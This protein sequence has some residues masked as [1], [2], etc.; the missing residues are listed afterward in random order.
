MFMRMHT[1]RHLF[2]ILTEQTK[3]QAI[4]WTR[5]TCFAHIATVNVQCRGVGRNF[6]VVRPSYKIAN[7]ILHITT[8]STGRINKSLRNSSTLTKIN[9]VA[10]MRAL[11]IARSK[12][13]EAWPLL[14]RRHC[15]ESMVPYES[16]VPCEQHHFSCI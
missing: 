14:F 13:G 15:K 6:K 11:M 1:P 2:T 12:S 4:G 7:S 3:E 10:T 8:S 5:F 16:M 9:L